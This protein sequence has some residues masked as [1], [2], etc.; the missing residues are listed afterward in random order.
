MP[1]RHDTANHAVLRPERVDSWLAGITGEPIRDLPTAEEMAA[2][3]SWRVTKPIRALRLRERVARIASGRSPVEEPASSTPRSLQDA[4]EALRSRLQAVAPALLG[5]SYTAESSAAEPGDAEPGDA[6]SVARLLAALCASVHASGRRDELWLLMVAVSGCFPDQAQLSGLVRDLRGA[7]EV[8]V[9]DRVLQHCGVWTIRYRSQL[10]RLEVVSDEAVVFLDFASRSAANLGIQR[11]T[12]E[13]LAH[14]PTDQPVLLAALTDDGTGFRPLG[15]A[16]QQRVRTGT[17]GRAERR[18]TDREGDV[19]L[20]V[21]WKTTVFVPEVPTTRGAVTLGTL[22]RYSGNRTVAF[23]YETVPASSGL[24]VSG[25][26]RLIFTTYLSML[27]YVDVIVTISAAGAEEFGGFA[28][29]LRAQGLPEPEIVQFG[30]PIQMPPND[31]ADT[32]DLPYPLVLAVGSN[33]PRK[34]HLAVLYAAELLWR[35]GLLFRLAVLGGEG[36][37]NYSAVADAAAALAASGRDILLRH[38]VSETELAREYRS[39]RFTV[40]L[41][42]HDSGMPVAESFAYGTPV[43]A[44]DFGGPAQISAGGGAL[45]VDPRDDDAITAAMRAMIVDDALIDRLTGEIANRDDPSWTDY[46]GRLAGVVL[47]PEGAR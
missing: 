15:E 11:I 13:T 24:H 4:R 43:L 40:F 28:Q 1:T 7:D 12:R 20:V 32:D 19:T 22:A 14:W 30:L 33:L 2:S 45:L 38:N 23:G 39:A 21:P 18:S 35:E 42:L 37:K 9:V 44:S 27:K 26:E 8:G 31:S 3:L 41:S 47:G 6:A 10:R 17:P 5:E 34:N 16:E 25:L 36:D 46:A 29:A